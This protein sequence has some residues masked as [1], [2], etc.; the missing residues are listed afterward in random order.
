MKG[1]Y[2]TQ[3]PQCDTRFKVTLEQLN[4]AHGLV[5]C[6]SC[7]K[8]FS[9]DQH[10][11]SNQTEQ[12]DKL[13]ARNNADTPKIPEIPLQ[14]SQI[15]AQKSSL[16]TLIWG[17]L[18]LIGCLGLL[19]QILWFERDQL[20]QNPQFSSFY[21]LACKKVNCQLNPRQDIPNITNQQLVV[22]DHPRY[23]G[24]IAVDLL[25]E[26]QAPFAQPFPAIRITF[27]DING[28]P[29]AARSFQPAEYLG[30]DFNSSQLMPSGKPVQVRLE[31]I[32]PGAQAANY[33]IQ[34]IQ[35][36]RSS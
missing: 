36:Q 30:G 13:T 1:Q 7:M 2:V 23:L 15:N 16:G 35:P 12:S 34:F 14:I 27:S 3:C 17:T 11:Q 28:E 21:Q 18:T 31:M 6:G 20:S 32:D 9:A 10:L 33:R 19:T 25:M 22:R 26:N 5:R 29:R 8:V 4:E 24:A